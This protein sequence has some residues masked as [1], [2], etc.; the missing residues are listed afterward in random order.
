MSSGAAV[1]R[2]ATRWFSLQSFEFDEKFGKKMYDKLVMPMKLVDGFKWT[3][4]VVGPALTIVSGV[5]LGRTL[6]H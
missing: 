3:A 1:K 2:V 6:R 5:F 4:V